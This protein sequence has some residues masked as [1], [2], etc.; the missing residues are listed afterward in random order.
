M[1]PEGLLQFRLKVE[2]LLSPDDALPEVLEAGPALL[3]SPAQVND[4]VQ[5][6]LALHRLRNVFVDLLK[7]LKVS[8]PGTFLSISFDESQ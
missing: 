5:V 6:S 1:L 3:G 7:N 4:V 2:L 8:E